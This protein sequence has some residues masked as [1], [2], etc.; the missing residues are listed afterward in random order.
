MLYYYLYDLYFYLHTFFTIT[1]N[2]VVVLIARK[3][4]I[5][6]FVAIAGEQEVAGH[7]RRGR[8]PPPLRR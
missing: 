4:L 5:N 7:A 8:V 6:G 1:T 3:Q 2:C